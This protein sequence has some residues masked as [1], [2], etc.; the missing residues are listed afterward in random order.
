M[1]AFAQMDIEPKSHS[2]LEQTAV[3]GQNAF[4]LRFC[5]ELR[6]THVQN[7]VNYPLNRENIV[8]PTEQHEAVPYGMDASV[9]RFCTTRPEMAG[10]AENDCNG[11]V[12][13]PGRSLM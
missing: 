3:V 13:S 11:S 2:V 6:T 1:N 12:T 9:I 5:P 10:N 7:R 4:R 8:P